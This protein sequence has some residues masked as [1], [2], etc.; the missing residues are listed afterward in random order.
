MQGVSLQSSFRKLSTSVAEAAESAGCI[1]R[2][3]SIHLQTAT[4]V[5]TLCRRI[6]SPGIPTEIA[7]GGGRL[8]V[9]MFIQHQLQGI[10]MS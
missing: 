7:E 4:G 5:W 1:M 3:D 8:P 9:S 6:Y 2:A 10:I